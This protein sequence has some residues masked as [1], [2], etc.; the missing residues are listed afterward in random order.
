MSVRTVSAGPPVV[1]TP[2]LAPGA[3]RPSSRLLIQYSIGFP[4]LPF[5]NSVGRFARRL[6]AFYAGAKSSSVSS[7]PRV[8]R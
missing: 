8:R 2:V 5:E 6:T 7:V 1:T 3:V 4:F